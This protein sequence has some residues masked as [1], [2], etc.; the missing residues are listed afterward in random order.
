MAAGLQ[1]LRAILDDEVRQRVGP[2]YQPEPGGVN[3]RWGRQ[4][5]YVVFGGQKIAV[6]RPRVRA[7]TG[8]AV[9]LDNYR[10]LQQDGRRQR[11]GAKV[12][13]LWPRHAVE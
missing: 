9:E 7:R 11:T 10:R 12:A 3:L 2:P 1:I 5:G 8:E 4:P 13:A 6:E